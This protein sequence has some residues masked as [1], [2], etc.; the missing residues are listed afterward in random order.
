MSDTLQ[1]FCPM[2]ENG[3]ALENGSALFLGRITHHDERPVS[4]A[5][6]ENASYTIF[7]LDDSD[8]AVRIPVPG[9]TEVALE[10]DDI[11]RN[12]VIVD[13]NWPFDEIGYNFHHVLDDSTDSPFPAAGRNYLA[14]YTLKPVQGPKI[15]IQYRVRVV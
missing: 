15:Q 5:E 13:E 14:A 8:A 11:L 7:R 3:R 12:D 2:K 4:P 10:I 6:I 1:L 9:H